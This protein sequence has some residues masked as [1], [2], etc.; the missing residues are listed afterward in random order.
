[1]SAAIRKKLI[2]VALPLDDINKACAREKSIRHGHP[3]TLHLWWARRPLAAARSVIFAQMVD[4]PSSFPELSEEE[5]IKERERLFDIIRDLVKWENTNNEEV[6]NRARAEIMKS[7]ARTCEETGEDPK[8]LPPFHDPFAG[9]GA[10][11]LEAQRLGFEAHASDLNPVAVMI[12]KAMIE[13]PPKFA[14]RP[15]IHPGQDKN[16]LEREWQGAS[17]L[18]EDVR[19]YGEWMR[20]RAWER[21][22]HLYPEVDLPEEQGGGKATV[23]AWLWART[24]KCPNPSCG[25]QMPLVRSFD[26]STK[27]GKRV[28][29][30]PK[31][32]TST[33]PHM[34]S[35]DVKMGDGKGPIGT[36]ERSGARCL[37][38]ESPVPLSYVRLEGS[39]GRLKDRLMAVVVE[40][41]RKR[42]YLP[43]T[44][45]MQEIAR[46][47]NPIDPPDT[48]LPDKAL[49]FRI[50]AY[51]MLRH[52]DLFTKRQ[53][54]ALT[55]FSDLVMDARNQAISDANAAGTLDDGKGIEDG[56]TGAVA[57][58]DALAVYLAFAVDKMADLSNSFCRWEPNAQCPRQLFGRQA[59]PMIWDYSE[60]NI[61]SESSGS[62][63]VHVSGS[64]KGFIS[65]A[66]GVKPDWIGRASQV[67]AMQGY[68]LDNRFIYSTD[69]PYYDNIGY[70]DLSDFFYVW[71]RRSL[72]SLFPLQLSTVLVPKAEELVATPYRHDGKESAELFF[73]RGMTQ[74]MSNLALRSHSSYP[75][76]IYY[77]FKQ[78]ETSNEGIASTGWSTFL[79][80]VLHSGL[81]IMGTWPMRTENSS[82]MV[83]Q[84][85]SAL[86]SSVV[87]V[88]NTNNKT[89]SVTT[90]SDFV[91]LLRQELP[92]ALVALKQ[93]SIA[94]VD[95]AQVA[96]GPGMAVFSRFSQVM[97]N[98]DSAMRVKSALQL[99]NKVLD[100]TLSQDEGDYDE[101][102]AF[103]VPW[104]EQHGI[105]A[106]DFGIADNLARA[107]GISV[108]GVVEAGI[109]ESK[110]GKVRLLQRT[111]LD[112]DWDPATDKRLTVWESLQYLIR[113]L[114]ERGE[115]QAAGLL[116][117][118]GAIG[119]EAHNLAY[120]LYSIC[121]RK[122]WSGEATHY[123][124]I[125]VA[126]PTL[127]ELTRDQQ[128]SSSEQSKLF[129]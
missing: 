20:D 74:V 83:G 18:A 78:K 1:M 24:I 16:L 127:N 92:I 103:A 96:I 129:E 85:T 53:L 48:D 50:Q 40:G 42:I 6:L 47:A 54:V 32:D 9:G 124:T 31:V 115:I 97:E 122:G 100:D 37:A 23:I 51:G 3:S 109:A 35:F 22:G 26:L 21:I 93:A 91:R 58:A 5:V 84:G 46:S 7:W 102:T 17:G 67:D 10:I 14:G 52:A 73:L 70:A 128:D 11:P 106:A 119:Q 27:K 68:S 45:K 76:T 89:T 28:W 49:G 87:L 117:R 120:R 98:D 101:W 77:A 80:A 13:I 2:E 112:P 43:A 110:A 72:K 88:C 25:C 123:N 15:P 121:E 41:V 66:V 56:G 81:Q 62:W 99:I 116:S 55:T 79:D 30:E 4:D 44:S 86:A 82:R 111:E 34:I 126:W 94:P 61:F 113:T 33:S 19:Y 114:D 118:L 57:Y 64:L 65:F 90:R 36:V 69:P 38:C 75:V 60:A 59:I 71:M 125:I 12:N 29:V 8:K 39:E 107:R 63:G 108:D 95:M 105:A 104:F